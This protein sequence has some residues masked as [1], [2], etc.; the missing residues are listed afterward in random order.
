VVIPIQEPLTAARERGDVGGVDG[1]GVGGTC[2]GGPESPG[3][4]D[5]ASPPPQEDTTA[6]TM[7]PVRTVKKHAP[8][9]PVRSVVMAG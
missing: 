1:G 8:A 6:D 9:N 3:G 7:I 4:G 5:T 2:G